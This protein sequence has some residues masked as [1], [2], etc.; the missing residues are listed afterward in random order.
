M[1]VRTTPVLVGSF[2]ALADVD[3]TS[4]RQCPGRLGARIGSHRQFGCD[5]F[6]LG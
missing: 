4:P 5:R 1:T 6:L 3:K 2:S